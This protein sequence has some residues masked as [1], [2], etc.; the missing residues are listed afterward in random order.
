MPFATFNGR[1]RAPVINSPRVNKKPGFTL[2]TQ[3]STTIQRPSN[4]RTSCDA[5]SPPDGSG[6]H[7]NRKLPWDIVGFFPLIFLSR[8]YIHPR[9]ETVIPL[10]DVV[11]LFSSLTWVVWVDTG[12][13]RWC[14]P[15][16]APSGA[17]PTIK[18]VK[19]SKS[20]RS[21]PVMTSLYFFSVKLWPATAVTKGFK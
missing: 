19:K 18:A 8:V 7:F 6:G 21:L 12:I 15:R 16:Q 10:S 5:L 2:N 14:S 4:L 1:K 9:L 17:F 11:V 3:S 13:C 20:A